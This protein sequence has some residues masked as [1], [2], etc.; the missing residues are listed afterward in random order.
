RHLCFH[1]CRFEEAGALLCKPDGERIEGV[2]TFFGSLFGFA[3][4]IFL[5]TKGSRGGFVE[6]P[7]AL[8]GVAFGTSVGVLAANTSG[9]GRRLPLS[10][11]S[12]VLGAAV[13]GV[14]AAGMTT[15]SL[16]LNVSFG[17]PRRQPVSQ[18][19]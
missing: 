3:S 5:S 6:W 18:S 7:S 11:F 15:S 8:P 1:T 17:R 2:G 10:L 14:W 16:H 4:W 13:G 12:K 19:F 9:E